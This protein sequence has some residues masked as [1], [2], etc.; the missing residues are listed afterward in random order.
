MHWS[1]LFAAFGG[2]LLGAA[3]GAVP[4]F[5]FTGLL[6]IVG[7]AAAASGGTELIGVAFGP[8]MG[9][10]VS[11]GG[12]VA[13]AAYAASK[14]HLKTGRDVIIGSPDRPTTVTATLIRVQVGACVYGSVW[15][16]ERGWVEA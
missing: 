9:P 3:I 16:K 5:V 12:G 14:G 15:A 11:F 6:A 4:V 8:V 10:H 13:A 7:V 1:S 2:G